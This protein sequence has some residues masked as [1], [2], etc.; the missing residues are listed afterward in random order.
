MGE[1]V[2]PLD[3]AMR[4]AVA[5]HEGQTDKTGR[6]YFEH[7]ERV[8]RL[9]SDE[10][11]KIVAYLHDVVEKGAGWSIERL[12]KEGFSSSVLSAVDALT[13]RRDE[14]EIAF[15]DRLAVN[16]L[17]VSI[18]QIDIADNIWQLGRKNVDPEKY[19][20]ALQMLF[21]ATSRSQ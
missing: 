17:A 1:I 7:C 10:D 6:P 14:P 8:A 12:R 11:G 20:H 19:C 4:I 13:M 5:A 15:I 21:R 3:R 16:P 18:K 2:K 9:I